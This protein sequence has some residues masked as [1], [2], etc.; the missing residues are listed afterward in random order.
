MQP[1]DELQRLAR[2]VDMN[3]KRLDEIEFQLERL[4]NVVRNT[5]QPFIQSKPFLQVIKGISLSEQV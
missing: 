5:N 1:K 2:L 4:Q 3:K